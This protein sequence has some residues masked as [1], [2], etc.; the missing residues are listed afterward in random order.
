MRGEAGVFVFVGGGGG[1]GKKKGTQIFCVPS[2]FL[3]TFWVLFGIMVDVV[4]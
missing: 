2:A 3:L 1:G 4:E